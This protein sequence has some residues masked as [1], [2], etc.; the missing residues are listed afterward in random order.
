MGESVLED[1][2][3]LAEC[4]VVEGSCID[5]YVRS[6]PI[7]TTVTLADSTDGWTVLSSSIT[8][9]NAPQSTPQLPQSTPQLA[10]SPGQELPPPVL[11]GSDSPHVAGFSP[12]LPIPQTNAGSDLMNVTGSKDTT[13]SGGKV[14]AAS[15]LMVKM[16]QDDIASVQSLINAQL[17]D[18]KI[19]NDNEALSKV[20]NKITLLP[21]SMESF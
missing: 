11:G 2:K 1:G 14:T 4:L 5:V 6:K 12:L 3:T 10:V 21:H 7:R 20:E 16:L 17:L 8:M 19:R 9:L 18:V 13:K 15:D